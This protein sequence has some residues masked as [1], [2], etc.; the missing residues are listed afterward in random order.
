MPF[1]FLKPYPNGHVFN[2]VVSG[3]DLQATF[4]AFTHDQWVLKLAVTIGVW[5]MPSLN[6]L[7]PVRESHANP[8]ACGD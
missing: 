6:L 5:L 3:S 4:E 2:R 1:C 7:H 8:F